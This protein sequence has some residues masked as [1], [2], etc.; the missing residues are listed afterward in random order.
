MECSHIN[1][2][3]WGTPIDGNP[4]VY[5]VFN[6][7]RKEIQQDAQRIIRQDNSVCTRKGWGNQ[8]L[9]RLRPKMLGFKQRGGVNS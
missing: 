1:H 3:F 5:K 7:G 4:H 8:K 9:R 6:T 2:S